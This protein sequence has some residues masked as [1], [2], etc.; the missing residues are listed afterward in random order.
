[1]KTF[2]S[3][4]DGSSEGLVRKIGRW[5][6]DQDYWSGTNLRAEGDPNFNFEA[7][8]AVIS[9]GTV[10]EREDCINRGIDVGDLDFALLPELSEFAFPPD[11][12][13]DPAF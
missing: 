5:I 11:F 13:S 9:T 8:C 1:M 7:A 6:D 3:T 4:R 10:V 2:R 12:P